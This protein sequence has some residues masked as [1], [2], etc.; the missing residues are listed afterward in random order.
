MNLSGSNSCARRFV[1]LWAFRLDGS[2][3][4][5]QGRGDLPCID[6]MRMLAVAGSITL[7]CEDLGTSNCFVLAGRALS[8]VNK[9]KCRGSQGDSALKAYWV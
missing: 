8:P 3:Y 6:N 2:D 7:P 4:I 9:Q 5:S 1:E